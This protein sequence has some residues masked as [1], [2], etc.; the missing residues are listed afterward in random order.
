MQTRAWDWT[1]LKVTNPIS[2]LNPKPR[3]SMSCPDLEN[4][5]R[6]G[7]AVELDATNNLIEN[8]VDQTL[9]DYQ[10]KHIISSCIF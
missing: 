8:Q 7:H 4:I 5:I 9:V 10:V 6:I 3:G 2:C 1:Q